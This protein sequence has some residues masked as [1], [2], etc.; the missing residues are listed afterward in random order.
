MQRCAQVV[1][2]GGQEFRPGPV[3]R[4]GR[5]LCGAQCLLCLAQ[6]LRHKIGVSLRVPLLPRVALKMLVPDDLFGRQMRGGIIL[7]LGTDLVGLGCSG[8]S[9]WPATAGEIG[10]AGR[11]INRHGLN[12]AT[13]IHA[14]TPKAK[15]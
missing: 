9:A 10:S 1:T 12:P 4:L 15:G 8:P 14:E 13:T 7:A 6:R 3:G 2:E 11:M 5:L